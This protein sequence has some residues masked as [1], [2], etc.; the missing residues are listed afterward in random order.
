V[1]VIFAPDAAEMLA[2]PPECT[3]DP[4]PLARHFEGERRA[5]H[6][7]GVATMVLK[8]FNVVEPQR[9]YFGKK[10]AQQ[11]AIVKR[12]TSDFNLPI[13]IVECATVRAEDG[14]ALSTRNAYLR[15]EERREAS[16][17]Y[18]ALRHIAQTCS[19]RACAADE[20]AALLDE[21]RALLP[22]LQL[23]YLAVVDPA[24]FEPLAHTLGKKSLL[25][26]GAATLGT[27]RL[28]DNV[29]VELTP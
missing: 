2:Q 12:M 21:A 28:I 13:E 29:D 1:D 10:D 20:L 24:K 6:F 4:G 3:V 7:R 5:G 22:P 25:A 14:L 11:L 23:E 9:A 15:P 26:V 17:L 16:R 18:R 27:T 8:L 19:G